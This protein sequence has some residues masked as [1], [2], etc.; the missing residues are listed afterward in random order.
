M[1]KKELL[2]IVPILKDPG[3]AGT[4][5]NYQNALQI[6]NSLLTSLPIPYG[7]PGIPPIYSHRLL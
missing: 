2:E 4:G 3:F 5:Q 1:L 6:Y 7:T